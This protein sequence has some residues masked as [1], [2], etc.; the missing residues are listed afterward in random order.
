[1]S[2]DNATPEEWRRIAYFGRLAAE[3]AAADL[4]PRDIEALN[5]VLDKPFGEVPLTTRAY[6]FLL[7][8]MGKV[9]ITS[10]NGYTTNVNPCWTPQTTYQVRAVEKPKTKPS[11]DWSQ[12]KPQFK[13]LAR[14]DDDTA[15]VYTAK[16]VP[17][18]QCSWFVAGEIGILN[19]MASYTPGNCDWQDSLVERPAGI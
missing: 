8:Q 17:S 3:S 9:H 15:Y 6:V 18:P 13:W 19:H 16:P 14:D 1:M 2:I 7:K 12:I 10:D 4:T 5:M 11:I